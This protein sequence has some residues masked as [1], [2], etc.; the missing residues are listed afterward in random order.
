MPGRKGM[1]AKSVMP[2]VQLLCKSAHTCVCVHV[3]VHVCMRACVRACMCE[4]S[5]KALFPACWACLLLV[6]AVRCLSLDP[7]TERLPV[8]PNQGCL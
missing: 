7:S 2:A 8:T 5:G 4:L 1:G 3:C 6:L